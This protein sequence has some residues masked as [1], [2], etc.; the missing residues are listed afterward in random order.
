VQ[1]KEE[2]R[3]RAEECV[4]LARN[5]ASPSHKAALLEMAQ[6][7]LR[8]Y[9]QAEKNS[10]SDLSYETPPPRTSVPQQ[11]QQQQQR[12]RRDPDR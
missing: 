7:W 11:L 3:E 9:D 6:A 10:Q 2:Y 1:Q 8:L 5:A 12:Q 4:R